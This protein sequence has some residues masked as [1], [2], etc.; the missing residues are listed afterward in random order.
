MA[1]IVGPT[2][3]EEFQTASANHVEGLMAYTAAVA[4]ND[5]AARAP[6]LQPCQGEEPPGPFDAFQRLAAAVFQDGV[7]PDDQV[8]YRSRG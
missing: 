3:A 7:G 8:P 4:G 1:A 5:Q 6:G 2:K